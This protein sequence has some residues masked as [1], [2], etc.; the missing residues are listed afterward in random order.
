MIERGVDPGSA[1][2]IVSTFSFM[3]AVAS[4][5]VG[6]LPS[7]WPIRHALATCAALMSAGAAWLFAASGAP[8]GFAGAGAF[9]LGVGGMLTLLPVVWAD[10]FGR[11]SYGAIRGLALSLQV[12]AQ[13][14][15]PLSAGILRDASGTHALSLALFATLSAAAVLIALLAR[16]PSQ[17]D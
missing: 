6:W 14:A 12:L 10:Y 13:A 3:S 16:P 1:A 5:A 4:F 15:G 11:A 9:G 7:H 8:A 17:R 2:L